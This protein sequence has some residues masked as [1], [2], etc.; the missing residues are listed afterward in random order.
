MPGAR[1]TWRLVIDGT[2][3]SGGAL[4]FS[5]RSAAPDSL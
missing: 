2:T 3:P 5:T 4:S 1:Y